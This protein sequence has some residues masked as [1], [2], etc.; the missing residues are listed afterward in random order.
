MF[1]YYSKEHILINIGTCYIKYESIDYIRLWNVCQTEIGF[2]SGNKIIID[3]PFI[4][5]IENLKK[6]P[7]LREVPNDKK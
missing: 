3:K 7:S 5:V 1:N 6:A 2:N 4:D